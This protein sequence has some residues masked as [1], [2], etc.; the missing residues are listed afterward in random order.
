MFYILFVAIVT[1]VGYSVQVQSACIA[2]IDACLF[3]GERVDGQ[4]V[5]VECCEIECLGQRL[6]CII[7]ERCGRCLVKAF[8]KYDLGDRECIMN[9]QNLKY[10]RT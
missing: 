10:P 3:V 1:I 4:N 2:D 5:C 9:F 6:A 8:I 7:T